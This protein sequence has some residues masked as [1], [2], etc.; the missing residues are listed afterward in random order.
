MNV[1]FLTVSRL[2]SIE[3][4]GIYSDLM[5]KFRNEG[6]QVYIV[7]PL[8]R[9]FHK[10]TSFEHREG[11]HFLGIKTLNVQKTNIVEKGIS[12]IL[13]EPLFK[14]AVD[15][16]IQNIPFDLIL[17]STPPVTF[18]KVIRYLKKN[19]PNAI[20]YLLLKDIFP[21]NAVDLGMF[22]KSSLFY[23][24]FRKKEKEL[25]Q[26]SDHIGCMSPANVQFVIEH[27]KNVDPNKVEIAAN[28]IDLDYQSDVPFDKE[29]IRSKY[30][31]PKDKMI[32]GYGGNLGKPQGVDFLIQCLNY[33]KERKDCFFIIVG[34]GTDYGKLEKWFHENKPQNAKLVSSLPVDEYN[35]LIKCCDVGMIFLDHRFLIPNFPS[36]LLSYLQNKMPILVA[37]DKNSDMGSIA[38]QNEFGYFGESNSIENFNRCLEKFIT[39]KEKLKQMGEKGYQHLCENY[40]I[41]HT[42]KAIAEHF[43]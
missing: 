6:H 4:N 21:Q 2:F 20:T 8:E 33:N 28:S 12:T 5:R 15:K 1:I 26:I 25:Y 16:Y 29:E 23:K 34:G 35:R 22:S 30:D 11:V 14:R 18:N 39:G 37:T 24:Y 41:E 9:R 7:Y 42:Y 13:L 43:K 36:R 10:D 3:K 31:L 27:N 32:F 17:Y 40:L 19:N 38:E